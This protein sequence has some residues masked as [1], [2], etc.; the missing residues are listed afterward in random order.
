MKLSLITVTSL[1]TIFASAPAWATLSIAFRDTGTTTTFACQDQSTPCDTDP[2]VNALLLSPTVIG[3]FTVTGSFAQSNA[4]SLSDANLTITNNGTATDTLVFSVGQTGYAGPVTDINMSGSGTFEGNI[5]GSG[6]AS[7][8]ADSADGQGGV[9]DILGN[10]TA[11]GTLLFNP[12]SGTI[13]VD[14][15]AFSGNDINEPFSSAGPFSMSLDYSI[16]LLPGAS[17]VGLESAETATAVPEI[18][19]W[20][21]ALAG[22][23]G[24]GFAAMRKGKRDARLAI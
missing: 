7:F 13:T 4:H 8:H 14:P 21:M 23:A 19:T 18:P 17:I 3:D 1:C 10:P 12:T 5:G 22:F 20:A 9:L 24:L 16:T 6:S 11:P 15:F 2:A